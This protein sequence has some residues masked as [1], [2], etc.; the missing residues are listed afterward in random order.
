M[1]HFTGL[2]QLRHEL[3]YAN[4]KKSDSK[5][6]G[7]YVRP[8][9]DFYVTNSDCNYGSLKLAGFY[10]SLPHSPFSFS[11]GRVVTRFVCEIVTRI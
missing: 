8:F 1:A 4:R 10:G 3:H 7:V 11:W 6:N 5:V 2:M 9:S